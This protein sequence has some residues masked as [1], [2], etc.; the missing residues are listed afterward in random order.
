MA[1]DQLL[2]PV[3]EPSRRDWIAVMSVMLGAFMAVLDIQITNSSL[4]DIQG[5]LSATLE[6]GSWISTSYL[7]A[8]IIMIPLTAWLVQLLSARRLAVWVSGGFLIASLMCSMAWSLESMIVF[9]ALQGFTGGALIPLAFTLTLIKLPEHHRAKGM[10]MF[11]MTATFAPSIGPTIGGWLTENWGWEYIFYINIPPGLIMIAGLLYGLE[12]K[13]SNWDLLKSTDY[14]GIVTMAVGL[15]CLQV[16]LEE[17]HRKDWLES[18]LIVSLGTVALLSLITFVI[19]QMSKPNPLINLRI[20]GNRN[21]GL[22]SISSLG[23]GVGLYGS[24]YLLP[25]YLAQIQNYNALQIGE[26]I[27]WMGVPQLFLIPLVPK[28]MKYVSPKWL[29]TL[30]FGLFGLASFSS[31]VLNP[32]FAGDQFNRIQI[33]RAL[34]QPLIMVTIS[35]IAT[36]YIM[37]KDA[38]SASSLFNILRNL[39]GA[40]GIALLATL[41]DARTKTYFDY[42]REAIVPTNPQVAERMARLTETFG[43]ET[44]A[45]GKLS[46][47]AHQQAQIMAYNDAFHFVGLAL[48]ISMVAILLTKALPAGLKAG[49]AH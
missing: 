16:F 40:I 28:L 47:I 32:D 1:G 7:V 10:A 34:G 37:Q 20:L 33:I 44:A 22:S 6:E 30:G 38:G 4:K 24:I 12:K 9:R 18:S 43:S 39:G 45:L 15:G 11:A 19:V 48:G 23:M 41:L 46:E 14:L 25:L 2:P 27:M 31:G 36:A 17:G 29:C 35:L 3:G 42:L 21:F 49:E 8:E 5:A 26:V 13:D